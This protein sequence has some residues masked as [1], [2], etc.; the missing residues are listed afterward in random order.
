MVA[1]LT[2]RSRHKNLYYS[3]NQT[4]LAQRLTGANCHCFNSEFCTERLAFKIKMILK[5]HWVRHMVVQPANQTNTARHSSFCCPV[6]FVSTLP[7]S[8]IPPACQSKAVEERAKKMRTELAHM[9]LQAPRRG[10]CLPNRISINHNILCLKPFTVSNAFEDN[11]TPKRY[12][13]LS[14]FFQKDL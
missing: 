11:L 14:C 5:T 8:K 4:Y 6:T 9:V 7:Q 10:G 13:E 1:K 3:S 2:K 12:C